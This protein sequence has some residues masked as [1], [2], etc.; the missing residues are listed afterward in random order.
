L[1]WIVGCLLRVL[2]EAAAMNDAG[3]IAGYG[4]LHG[5]LHAFLL[6]PAQ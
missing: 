6:L 2:E 5:Q 1:L 4:T 3:Q